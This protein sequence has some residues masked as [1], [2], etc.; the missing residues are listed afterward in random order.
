MKKFSSF[1]FR[2]FSPSNNSR[3]Y[4]LATLIHHSAVLSKTNIGPLTI[5]PYSLA[6]HTGSLPIYQSAPIII[7]VIRPRSRFKRNV[8]RL[9]I[10]R[11]WS[12]IPFIFSELSMNRITNAGFSRE[13]ESLFD[14]I[15]ITSLGYSVETKWK[16]GEE[17]YVWR[18]DS[19][20]TNF[21]DR[22]I[23]FS[24]ESIGNHSWNGEGGSIGVENICPMI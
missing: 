9:D 19:I 14:S 21:I 23:P 4:K 12:D 7:R 8:F 18:F 13:L 10:P 1:F 15:I 16:V 2:Q 24:R 6:V 22:W 5:Y 20:F 3:P 17:S 11:N